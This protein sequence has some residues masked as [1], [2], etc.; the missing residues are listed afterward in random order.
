MSG[1]GALLRRG[2]VLEA[3]FFERRFFYA[4]GLIQRLHR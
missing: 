3:F 4:K 2:V 1:R